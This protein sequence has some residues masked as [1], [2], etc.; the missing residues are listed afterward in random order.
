MSSTRIETDTTHGSGCILSSAIASCIAQEYSVLESITIAKAYV[1]QAI[2]NGLQIGNGR[3]VPRFKGWPSDPTDYP[4][5]TQQPDQD[6]SQNPKIS[7][8]EPT[9][10]YI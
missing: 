5:S 6:L 4:W 9:K 2:R 10:K 1:H 8:I 3:G 7:I